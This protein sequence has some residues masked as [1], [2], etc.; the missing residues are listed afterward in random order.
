MHLVPGFHPAFDGIGDYARRLVERLREKHG[1]AG[2]VL[3]GDPGWAG[4]ADCGG[5]PVA[6]LRE[7]SGRA[8]AGALAGH[9]GLVLHYV[10]YGYQKR[11]LPFWLDA[12]IARWKR[13]GGG[14]RELVFFHEIW[15]S[16]PLSRSEGWLGWLQRILVARR[17]RAADGVATSCER[18]RRLLGGRVGGIRVVPIPSNLPVLASARGG[19]E[20]VTALVFGQPGSR[21]PALEWH[22]PLL[23]GL[24]E[25]GVLRR[26]VLAG[27]GLRGGDRPTPDVLL[28]REAA[29]GAPV[30]IEPDASERRLAE[31]F[32]EADL[33]LSFHPAFLACKSTVVMGA[34]AA[35]C[36]PVLR[37]EEDPAPL[38]P[39]VHFLSCDGSPGS[40]ARVV[41]LAR[42]GG[43][44]GI[45]ESARRWYEAN[46]SWGIVA[47]RFAGM[48]REVAP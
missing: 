5:I 28:A 7:R 44:S 36:V 14:R 34:S 11:G 4:P 46:A 33:L 22:R 24:S 32:A 16:G 45:G 27:S 41:G 31:R 38:E 26:L 3:V 10:P 18:M 48:L 37:E 17:C 15:A 21:L 9:R 30:E 6:A 8:L 43:L 1:I 13:E 42:S 40:V 23:R 47:A 39:G 25:A 20:G 29:G 12:G 2:S 19:G 35:G